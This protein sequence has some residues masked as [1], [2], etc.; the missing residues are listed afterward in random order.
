[1]S[2]EYAFT[3]HWLVP[4][5]ADECW[6]LCERSLTTGVVAWWPAVRVEPQPHPPTPGDVVR[7]QVRSPWGY[8]LRVALTITAATPPRLLAAASTGDLAGRGSLRLTP[9]G[10]AAGARTRLTWVWE[11]ALVRRWMRVASPVL[12]P[13]FAAAHAIVM[14]RGERGFLAEI[15]RGSDVRNAGNP[16]DRESPGTT[17][18]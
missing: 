6:R 15:V 3:S 5:S 13:A 14:R 12:R 9:E 8:R 17:R 2:R 18:G 16:G 4:A 10:G 11:V 7:L 1:M